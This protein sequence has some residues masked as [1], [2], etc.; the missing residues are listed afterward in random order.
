M[1]SFDYARA[2]TPEAAVRQAGVLTVGARLEALRAI[3]AVSYYGDP[4]VSEIL[5][6]APRTG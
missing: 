3:A 4:R 6:Y 1:R 5:G 2:E